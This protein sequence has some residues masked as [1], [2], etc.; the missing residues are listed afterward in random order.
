MARTNIEDCWWTDP[1]RSKLI[2]LLGD[3]DRADGVAVKMWRIAQEFWKKDRGLVPQNIF[4]TLEN[5]QALVGAGLASLGDD[6]VYVRGSSQYLDWVHE[7]REKSKKGGQESAKRPRDERG[8]LLKSDA[9]TQP[10]SKQI[11][12]SDSG[13][14]SVSHSVSDSNSE[15]LNTISTEPKNS[16]AVVKTKKELVSFKISDSK[17]ISIAKDLIDSWVDT[18]PKEFLDE[19]IKKARSWVLSNP[20]KTPKSNWGRFLNSW[21]NRG[22]DRY[23]TTLKSNPT[24]I[25]IDDLNDVLGAL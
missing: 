12:A 9:N 16:V 13:S 19:E 21:F 2:K 22:W 3:E 17:T 4:E 14:I 11:Q 6:G 7:Q 24:K 23:R 25:T 10:E 8:R 18:F 1:R 5:H 15:K 20:H